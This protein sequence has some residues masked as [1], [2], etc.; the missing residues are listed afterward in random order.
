MMEWRPSQ[1]T[2]RSARISSVAVRR[3]CTHAGNAPVFLD[4]IDR[5]RTHAQVEGWVALAVIGEE[6]KEIPLRH[7]R[8]IFAV[9]R[10]VVEIAR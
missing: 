4:Q 2:T 1:P 8:N 6:I 3:L 5:F 10:Q 7:E 9:H